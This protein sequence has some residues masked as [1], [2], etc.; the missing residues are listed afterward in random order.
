VTGLRRVG[1]EDVNAD[2]VKLLT[3]I[4]FQWESPRQCGSAFMQ[5]YR[6][7]LERLKVA[8]DS[9][10]DSASA[11]D[12]VLADPVVQQWIQAQREATKRGALSATRQH[13]MEGV[14]GEDWLTEAE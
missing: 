4:G 7:I 10:V 11:A 2:H 6:D 3:N 8:A 13:Y 14:A 5:Q 12:E 9:D 1:A